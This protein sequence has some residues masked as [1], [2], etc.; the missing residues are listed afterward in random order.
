MGRNTRPTWWLLYVIAVLLVGVVGL[1]EISVQGDVVRK[2]LD[3]LDVVAGFGLI[4]VW[5]RRNRSAFDR[6]RDRRRA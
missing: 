5:V 6:A 1:V 2:I 4:G 3:S